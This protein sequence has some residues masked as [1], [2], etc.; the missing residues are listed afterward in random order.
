M[1]NGTKFLKFLLILLVFGAAFFVLFK[2]KLFSS[3]KQTFNNTIIV[4]TEISNFMDDLITTI[5][6]RDDIQLYVISNDAFN[7]MATSKNTI[8]IYSGV[9]NRV[10]DVEVILAIIAH[11]LGHITQN[12]LI[13]LQKKLDGIKAQN[14]ISGL[15]SIAALVA[16][17][18]ASP[19]SDYTAVPALTPYLFGD[20]STKAILSYSQAEESLADQFMVN[21]FLKKKISLS[22]YIKFVSTLAKEEDASYVVASGYLS[23][24][25][26]MSDRLF[27]I[28]QRL[29]DKNINTSELKRLPNEFSI[30]YKMVQA[31]IIGLTNDKNI[32]D[33]KYSEKHELD[34]PYY[35]YSLGISNWFNKNYKEA[36][37]NFNLVKYYL[38]KP[39][40]KTINKGYI[41]EGIAESYFMQGNIREAIDSYE[42]ALKELSLLPDK[43][44]KNLQII[45]ESFANVLI[46]SK[47]RNDINRG[48]EILR[49]LLFKN[50]RSTSYYYLSIAYGKIDDLGRAH[51]YLAKYFES[52][53][54]IGQMRNHMEKAEKN[55]DKSTTEYQD[56]LTMKLEN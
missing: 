47:D 48:I 56:L 54:N 9:F 29:I 34:T 55:L 5:S 43:F 1:K 38:N 42:L 2:N 33:A 49:Q 31:K 17:A 13:R 52:I 24:H 32:I 21:S 6:D 40:Y 4:D 28:K 11:E 36:L 14:V 18:A 26:K 41:F 45:K 12:H 7:A 20:I 46:S 35:F 23:D 16:M 19:K 3:S 27:D 51:Y 53:G 50:S 30:K 22:E 37:S 8:S 44:E 25:P 10:S 15:V 39:E